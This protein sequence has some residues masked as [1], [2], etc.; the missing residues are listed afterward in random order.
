MNVAILCFAICFNIFELAKSRL[1]SPKTYEDNLELFLQ[2][3]LTS[4]I[5]KGAGEGDGGLESLA[6]PKNRAPGA[7]PPQVRV[8]VY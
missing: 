4:G 2:S 8:V 7:P 6:L 3:D 5:A 1:Q